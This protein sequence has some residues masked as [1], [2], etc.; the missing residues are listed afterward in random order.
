MATVAAVCARNCASMNSRNGV[1]HQFQ[2]PVGTAE[3]TIDA[4]VDALIDE[5]IEPRKLA[6]AGSG[7]LA[8]EG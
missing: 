6:F 4:V 5:V 1:R 3:E 8:W 2:L 7:H